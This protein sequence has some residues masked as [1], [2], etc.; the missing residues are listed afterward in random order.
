MRLFGLARKFKL[1]PP[2]SHLQS[3]PTLLRSG[4]PQ[5][6][7]FNL[8][9]SSYNSMG[10]EMFTHRLMGAVPAIL[11]RHLARLRVLQTPCLHHHRIRRFN[12]IPISH[13]LGN[14]L[15]LLLILLLVAFPKCRL[16]TFSFSSLQ[17]INKLVL[18][19]SSWV[20]LRLQGRL[21]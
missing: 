10:A 16:S 11:H 4:T 20:S 2:A 8:P 15:E 19:P 12:N 5:T 13:L 21:H 6:Q 14:H 18:R 9:Q 7:S 17:I 1:K 3:I